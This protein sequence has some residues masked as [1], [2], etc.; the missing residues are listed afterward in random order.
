MVGC[1][2]KPNLEGMYGVPLLIEDIDII[3]H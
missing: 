2:C 1:E 3:A